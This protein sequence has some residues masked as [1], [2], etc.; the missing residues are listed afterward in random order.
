MEHSALLKRH[1][2]IL[3]LFQDF[4]RI[5]HCAPLVMTINALLTLGQT[6]LQKPRPVDLYPSW[7][8]R[9]WHDRVCLSVLRIILRK[10]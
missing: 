7:L 2:A 9:A 4:Y 6:G 1:I 8:N 5:G 10:V 3:L